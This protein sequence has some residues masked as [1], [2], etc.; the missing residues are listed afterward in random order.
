MKKAQ[1]SSKKPVSEMY[2]AEERQKYW[3]PQK[4]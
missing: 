3:N 4:P 1:A 2:R